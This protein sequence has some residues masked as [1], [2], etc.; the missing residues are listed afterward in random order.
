[1]KYIRDEEKNKIIKSQY[2]RNGIWFEDIMKAILSNHI[3]YNWPND[4]WSY[5]KQQIFIV[6]IQWYPY[7]VPYIDFW[8]KTIKL[9]TAYPYR[10]FKL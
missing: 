2:G 10:K 6:V 4:T 3:I 5:N 9:I 8:D 7:K 1:M